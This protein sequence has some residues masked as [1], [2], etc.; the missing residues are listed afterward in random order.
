MSGAPL[1]MSIQE[2]PAFFPAGDETL[3]GILTHPAAEPLGTAV[4]LLPGGSGTRISISRNR[5]WVELARRLAAAG[6]HVLRFDNYGAGESTGTAKLQRLDEPFSKDVEGAVRWARSQ[7]VSR[8]VLVGACFG[9]RTAL[10]CAPAVPGLQGAV[11]AA[12]N[13]RDYRQGEK[14]VTRMA[15]EWT[16]GMYVRRAFTGRVLKGLFDRRRRRVYGKAIRAKWRALVAT[17]RRGHRADPSEASDHFVDPL[18]T[19]IQRDIPV[20]FLYGEEDDAWREFDR[21]R[22]G[23]LGRL[24]EQGSSQVEVVTFPG[25]V[26]GL[27][28]ITIQQTVAGQIEDW[29]ARRVVGPGS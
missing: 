8:F 22:R 2:T 20:L 12:P 27:S 4:I 11:L 24:L 14:S 7:G 21:A 9:A 18:S 10:S 19:L 25:M 5:I 26:H 13:A 6:Y 1:A 16:T 15:S 23:R 28:T 3:F 17:V 29:L